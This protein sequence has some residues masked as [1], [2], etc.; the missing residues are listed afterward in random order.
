M[1]MVLIL[2]CKHCADISICWVFQVESSVWCTVFKILRYF[3]VITRK[4][5][6]TFTVFTQWM[7]CSS[8]QSSSRVLSPYLWIHFEFLSGNRQYFLS[9]LTRSTVLNRLFISTWVLQL[10]YPDSLLHLCQIV[11]KSHVEIQHLGYNWLFDNFTRIMS[12]LLSALA[13]AV[14]LL[15]WPEALLIVLFFWLPAWSPGHWLFGPGLK[16]SVLSGNHSENISLCVISSPNSPLVLDH[17]WLNYNLHIGWIKEKVTAW[18]EL[19]PD[20]NPLWLMAS[21]KERVETKNLRFYPL[22]F[23]KSCLGE[24]VQ[25]AEG[26]LLATDS[27][28]PIYITS[29]IQLVVQPIKTGEGSYGAEA[30]PVW[31]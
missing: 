2:V 15:S 19:C 29:T 26:S 6:I 1:R 22:F 7:Y 11:S 9:S 28:S 23:L 25:Q 3:L 20:C 4:D 18:N 13:P 5:L 27:K 30:L 16:W 12:S 17:T 14:S 21:A 8:I 10:K 31:Q 24:G